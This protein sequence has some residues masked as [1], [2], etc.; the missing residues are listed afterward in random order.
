MFTKLTGPPSGHQLHKAGE[1]VERGSWAG[2]TAALPAVGLSIFPADT[3]LLPSH[4]LQGRP[5]CVR[6]PAGRPR[7][8]AVRSSTADRLSITSLTPLPLHSLKTNKLGKAVAGKEETQLTLKLDAMHSPRQQ[9]QEELPEQ[10]TSNILVQEFRECL[11]HVC[12][13]GDK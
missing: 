2:A 5:G 8:I 10:N 7:K 6:V 11:I 4:G 9:V 13:L 12:R 3:D 1:G